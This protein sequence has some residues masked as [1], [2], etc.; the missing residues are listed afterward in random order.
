MSDFYDVKPNEYIP[1]EEQIK[2]DCEEL[3]KKWSERE[4][5][6]R[7]GIIKEHYEIPTTYFSEE[8]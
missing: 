5:Y 6:K 8:K 7:L 1:S 4:H 2:K 3:R